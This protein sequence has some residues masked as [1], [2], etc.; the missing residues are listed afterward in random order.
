[1]SR[2][3]KTHVTPYRA[4]VPRTI[5]HH[6]PCTP[7]QVPDSPWASGTW[8]HAPSAVTVNSARV[9]PAPVNTPPS[10]TTPAS[11]SQ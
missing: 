3:K 8:K 11:S 10:A 1:M 4:P 2:R 9:R 6:T 7:S 5:D